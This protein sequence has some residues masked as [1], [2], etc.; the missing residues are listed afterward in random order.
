MFTGKYF[1]ESKPSTINVK[2]YKEDEPGGPTFGKRG[3]L[4]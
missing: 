3:C 4:L 2:G 1:Q